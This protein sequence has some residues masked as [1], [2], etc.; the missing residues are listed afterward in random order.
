MLE[1][2]KSQRSPAFLG[3]VIVFSQDRASAQCIIRNRSDS[4]ARLIV[5]NPSFVPDEFELTIPQQQMALR[6]RAR[7]RGCDGLGIEFIH[8]D[9]EGALDPKAVRRIKRLEIENRRL[10]RRLRD[11][12]L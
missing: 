7:W 11:R 6:A 4:G 1:R 5:H 8:A 9:E 10:K 12:T 2:R 3:G